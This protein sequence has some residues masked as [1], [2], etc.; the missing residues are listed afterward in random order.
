[1]TLDQIEVV[2]EAFVATTKR[3]IEVGFDFI[4]LHGAH[5]SVVS[6]KD[7]AGEELLTGLLLIAL[8]LRKAGI[9]YAQ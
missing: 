8:D 9:P 4:E 2:K 7:L 3:C 6:T 1:M 5:V